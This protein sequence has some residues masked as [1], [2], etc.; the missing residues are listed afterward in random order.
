MYASA[1]NTFLITGYKGTDPEVPLIGA[2]A[3]GQGPQAVAGLAP[4]VDSRD[5]YPTTRT[6]T[7]GVTASF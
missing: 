3:A 2:T 7:I 5:A 1:L 6:Y 4:G